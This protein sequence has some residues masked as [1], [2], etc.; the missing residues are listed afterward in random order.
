MKNF[1]SK[2]ASALSLLPVTR[3]AAAL[4]V[5][6]M[7]MT[8]TAV[9]ADLS[10]SVESKLNRM[11]NQGENGRPRTTAQ[12]QAKNEELKGKPGEQLEEIGKETADAVSNMADIYPQNAKTL[13]PGVSNGELPKDY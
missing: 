10:P 13:T 12:W 4:L 11:I 5:T 1:F 7:L 6:L 3:I 2:L 9:A 8:T